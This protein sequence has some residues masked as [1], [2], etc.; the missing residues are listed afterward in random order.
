MIRRAREPRLPPF[1]RLGSRLREMARVDRSRLAVAAAVPSAAATWSRSWPGSRRS[2]ADG[3]TAS[4]GALIVGFANLGGRYRIRL[5]TLL[6]TTARQASRRWR[7]GLAGAE[8]PGHGGADEPVGVRR[9]AAGRPRDAGRVRRDAV[10]LGL[11]LA[12]DLHLHGRAVLHEAGL[13]TAGGLIQTLIDVAAW[14]LRPFA[15]ERRAVAD[16]YR[17]LRGVRPVA[18]TRRPGRDRRGRAAPRRPRRSAGSRAA[19]R[20]RDLRTMIEQGEWIRL[21]LVAL[22]RSAAPGAAAVLAAAASALAAIAAG[23]RSGPRSP[24]CATRQRGGDRGSRR[25]PA[26]ASLA[27]WIGAA[28]RKAGPGHPAR[29]RARTARRAAGRAHACAPAGFRHAARLSL[30]LIAAGR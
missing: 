13:I 21:E 14:P 22:A 23:R 30:A 29:R 9:R 4:A 3:V 17:A 2:T 7:G 25:A 28:A 27:R 18:G 15:A 5:A 19:R 11:L 24:S 12:G 26:A 8:R 6:A 16:A 20:A 10:H 1:A